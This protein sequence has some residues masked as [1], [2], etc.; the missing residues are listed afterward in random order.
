MVC[1]CN[2]ALDLVGRVSPSY[3]LQPSLAL[4]S[5]LEYSGAISAHCILC[6][7]GSSDSPAS[8]SRVAGTTGACYHAWLILYF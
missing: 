6:L 5:K 1:V 7:P 4:S 2:T 3:C 8:V